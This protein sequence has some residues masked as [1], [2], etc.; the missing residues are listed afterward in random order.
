MSEET[1]ESPQNVL[2]PYIT[3]TGLPV[4]PIAGV[5]YPITVVYCGNCGLP[6]EVLDLV[7]SKTIIPNQILNF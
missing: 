2:E 5:E 4:G 3:D 1:A 6:T 7:N